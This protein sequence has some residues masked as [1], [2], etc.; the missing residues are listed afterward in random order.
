M[1]VIVVVVGFFAVVLSTFAVVWLVRDRPQAQ[2][3]A[4]QKKQLKEAEKEAELVISKNGP[5]PKAVIDETD[6]TFGRMALGETGTH[7][8]VI[9][10]EG[11]APLRL[12]KGPTTCQCTVSRL[13]DEEILPGQS[14]TINLT[15]EPTAQAEEFGKGAEIRTNDPENSSIQLKILGAVVPIV[16]AN[17][18]R[19]WPID[20]IRENGP[21]DLFTKLVSPLKEEFAITKI[22]SDSPL[23][24][25]VTEPITDAKILSESRGLS[26]YWVKITVQPQVPVGAFS[27]PVRLHTDLTAP[28]S[29]EPIVVDAFVTGQRRGP[30]RI[31]GSRWIENR[32]AIGF[33]QFDAQEGR[34]VT[35]TLIPKDEPAE[36][37]Q[38]TD[39]ICQPKELR[40]SLAL[41]EKSKTT[42]HRYALTVE[43]PAG[44]PRATFSDEHPAQIELR[45]N[46]ATAPVLIFKVL[47]TAY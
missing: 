21:T 39:V 40:V 37:L 4:A 20:E 8:F 13:A 5:W 42:P 31:L 2:I 19:I 35:L 18:D 43:Y 32:S 1:R 25:V 10:N 27:F 22:E 9:R 33:G 47:F 12:K 15:W 7:D 36:G 30:I 44:A 38:V 34:K 26:G 46:H 11:E 6:Y 45:T 17:P 14:A 3:E 23:V 16:I 28:N 41:D 29:G 24:K